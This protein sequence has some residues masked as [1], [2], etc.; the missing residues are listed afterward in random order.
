MI[1]F[2]LIRFYCY[3]AKSLHI[4]DT[5]LWCNTRTTAKVKGKMRKPNNHKNRSDSF[6]FGGWRIHILWKCI[7]FH[8][9]FC[10][11]MSV[12]LPNSIWHSRFDFILTLLQYITIIKCFNF[13]CWIKKYNIFFYLETF[14]RFFFEKLAVS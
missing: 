9:C 13:K 12:M 4:F 3:C 1:D 14:Q 11:F 5:D 7:D 8:A 6:F 10:C 2:Q